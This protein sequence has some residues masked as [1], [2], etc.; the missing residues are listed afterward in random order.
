MRDVF[1][2]DVLLIIAAAPDCRAGMS[3]TG[4]NLGT[5]YCRKRY[6]TFY[7]KSISEFQQTRECRLIHS[8]LGIPDSCKVFK[9]KW[10]SELIAIRIIFS[11]LVLQIVKIQK[12]V[13]LVEGSWLQVVSLFYLFQ[14]FWEVYWFPSHLTCLKPTTVLHTTCFWTVCNI[15]TPYAKVEPKSQ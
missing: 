13:T 1:R 6:S 3:S 10:R 5:K 12:R 2:A 8:F 14:F 11:T 15:C 7:D 4:P 9:L